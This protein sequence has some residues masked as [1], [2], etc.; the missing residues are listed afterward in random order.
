MFHLRNN[1]IRLKPSKAAVS[2]LFWLLAG[3]LANAAAWRS[4]YFSDFYTDQIFPYWTA[5][6]GSIT[7]P[8][9]FSLGECLIAAGL[10]WLLVLVI[11]ATG[12]MWCLLGRIRSSFR[13]FALRFLK[14]TAWLLLTIFLL[15]TSGC[16]IQYH[17]TPLKSSLPGYGKTYDFEDLAQLRDYVVIQCNQLSTMVPRDE[18]GCVIY[19]GGE[20]AMARQAGLCVQQ[21]SSEFPRLSGFQAVP[22]A[23]TAS[24]FVSQQNMQGYYFPFS[25]EANYNGLMQI[26]KKP[27]TMC[28]ELAHTHGYIYEDEANFLAFLACT[29]SDDPVFAYS[30]WLGI[31][32]YVD[33]DFWYAAGRDVYY[34]HIQVDPLVRSDN[35]FL[36]DEVK[37][38]IEKEALLDSQKVSDAA[39]TYVDTTLKANGVA[40]GKLSYNHVVALMLA[41][42]D[43]EY[44]EATV[45]PSGG[46]A[47][48][49]GLQ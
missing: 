15:L 48:C 24:V 10:V 9:P 27:F 11:C 35:K 12:L 46:Q 28:H 2:Y 32:N 21:L 16:L 45:L 38:K 30:G 5:L 31:L 33:N 13:R 14:A 19:E 1:T 17:C 44:P 49:K 37:E 41:W 20:T 23:L 18:H 29:A 7:S 47:G 36:S 39:D 8:L 22:K 4:T 25:M 43:G 6:Y 3:I 26:M 34:T 40:S 42:F